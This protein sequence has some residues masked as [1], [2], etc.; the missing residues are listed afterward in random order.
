MSEDRNTA[1]HR[2]A[3]NTIFL[4]IRMLIVL[5]INLYATRVILI[6]L[7]VEDYGIYNVVCGFVSMVMFINTSLTNGIQRFYNYELGSNG[8][9]GLSKVYSTAL[10]I[11]IAVIAIVILLTETIGLWYLNNKMVIPQEKLITAR[12]IYQ[13]S[14]ISFILVILQSPY[15]AAIIA[16]ERMDYYAIVSIVIN[17]LKLIVAMLL[18][19]AGT[20]RLLNYSL[21][22]LIVSA[23]E[24][25]MY[26]VYVRFKFQAIKWVRIVDTS[27]FKSMCTFSGWNIFGSFSNL[28]KEQGVNLILN[29]FCGPIA[30]AARAVA[31]QV[32]GGIQSFI[33][34]FTVPIRPQV[35][36]SYAA[37]DIDRTMSLTYTIS[38]FSC[39]FLYSLALPLIAEIDFIL[40]IWLGKDVPEYTAS[41]IIIIIITSFLSNLNAAVSG[42]I[43][44]SGKMKVYQLSTSF[45]SLLSLPLSY[46]V[47]KLSG[48]PNH[49]LLMVLFAM[50]AVQIV[51]LF[52]LKRIVEF[53]LK[54][55]YKRVILPLILV[56]VTTFYIPYVISVCFEPSCIR[57]CFNIIT[58]FIFVVISIY[59]CGL[60]KSERQICNNYGKKILSKLF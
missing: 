35:I 57:A 4:S 12:Y 8:D 30:N 3:K 7:G 56:V 60:S 6:N 34:N 29:L 18:P 51:A 37:G 19:F 33:N 53:S 20:Q 5:C 42:V 13:F 28:M 21:F 39:F 36:K 24:F 2:I 59:F 52:I 17:T 48:N 11:Q 58:S 32:N 50:I 31:S 9:Q 40:C 49:A 16:Y 44:A 14:I 43:H 38:K 45:V 47:L 26:Y 55:Y 23:L 41:F 46:L 27:L 1:N 10:L 15:S 25:L 54:T 22:L